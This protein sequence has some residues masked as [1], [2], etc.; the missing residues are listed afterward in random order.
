MRELLTHSSMATFRR[1]RRQWWYRYEMLLRPAIDREALGYGSAQHEALELLSTAGL[2]A[3]LAWLRVTVLRDEFTRQSLIA[4]T[5]AYAERYASCNI[6][7]ETLATEQVFSLPLRNPATNRRSGKWD[8]GGKMDRIVRLIDSR[9]AILE[10]KTTTNTLDEDYWSRLMID[11]QL[12]HYWLAA[13]D[14]GYRIETSVYD[15]IRK[16]TISPNTATPI[17]KRKYTKEGRLYANQREYDETPEGW[18]ERLLA[19][20]RERPE[21]YFARQEVARLESDLDAFKWE[22]WQIS[23]S[24]THCRKKAA[25]YRSPSPM[26]CKNCDYFNLCA[27]LQAYEPG[28]CPEGF[29]TV[30]TPHTELEVDNGTAENAAA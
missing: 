4:Y 25:Y 7:A 24:I 8:R 29:V 27:G 2:D 13:K 5:I 20:I 1:C 3:A 28:E 21:W 30:E 22:L 9:E 14:L 10:T 23:E 16:P 19:D 12:S 15:V 11:A 18:G 26:T 6:V 17:E